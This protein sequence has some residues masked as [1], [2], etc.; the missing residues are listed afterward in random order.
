MIGLKD[1]E[2]YRQEMLEH[3]KPINIYYVKSYFKNCLVFIF[4]LP[5]VRVLTELILLKFIKKDYT[6]YKSKFKRLFTNFFR[7]NWR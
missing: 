7:R 4:I 2:P 3:S 1:L 6:W 5:Q